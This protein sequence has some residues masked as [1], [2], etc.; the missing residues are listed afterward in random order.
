M[1]F[2][3]KIRSFLYKSYTKVYPWYLRKFYGMTIGE[4]TI[5]SRRANLDWNVNPK[6]IHI[7]N[8]T[9]VTGVTILTHDA[10]RGIK[11][12]V[13]IGD[14]CFI[15]GGVILPGVHIGNNCIVGIGSIVTKDIP[16]NSMVAGNPARIIRTGIKT[17]RHG[18]LIKESDEHLDI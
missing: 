18:T 6:G 5:I 14:N 10:C 12:D 8:H 2:F 17:G 7:G 3:S 9:L 1:M 11:A 16:D 13:F 15:G 4:D